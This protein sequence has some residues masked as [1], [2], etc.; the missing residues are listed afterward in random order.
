MV[1][2]A[3]TTLD[4]FIAF[5]LHPDNSERNFEFINGEIIEMSPGRT[6]YSE[7]AMLLAVFVYNF[8]REA[9]VPCHIS[10]ADGAFAINEHVIVPDFAYKPTPMSLDY[11]DPVPPIWAVEVISPTDKALDIQA[12]RLIYLEA[13]IILW[14][15]YYPTKTVSVYTPGQ[16]DQHFGIDDTLTIENS[17]PGFKLPVRDLLK[18][19][20]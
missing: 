7:I 1:D 3:F 10:G 4:E 16:P 18:L 11:P 6:G 9:D 20:E 14:E 17:L 19:S 15:V 8:C 12:K 13:G 2:R 5:A